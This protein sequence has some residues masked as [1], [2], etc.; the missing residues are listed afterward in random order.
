MAMARMVKS[1][2]KG[3]HKLNSSGSPQQWWLQ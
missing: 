3:L 1:N 2:Q